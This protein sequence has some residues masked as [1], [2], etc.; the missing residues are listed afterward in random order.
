MRQDLQNMTRKVAAKVTHGPAV[1][2]LIHTHKVGVDALIS[3]L[4]HSSN[5]GNL[6]AVHLIY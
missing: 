5:F 1:M 2:K 6:L 4:K 3:Q